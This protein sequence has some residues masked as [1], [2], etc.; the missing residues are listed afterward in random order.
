MW[1]LTLAGQHTQLP[2]EG[3]AQGIDGV[4]KAPDCIGNVLSVHALY[5]LRLRSADHGYCII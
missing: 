1:L 5:G 4:A 3:L 2:W